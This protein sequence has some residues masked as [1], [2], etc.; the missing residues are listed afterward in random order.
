[1]HAFPASKPFLRRRWAQLSIE[2]FADGRRIRAQELEI[3][4]GSCRSISCQLVPGSHHLDT[5]LDQLN[6]VSSQANCCERVDHLEVKRRRYDC[7]V[8]ARVQRKSLAGS[9]GACLNRPTSSLYVQD[10]P[11]RAELRHLCRLAVEAEHCAQHVPYSAHATCAHLL[12]ALRWRC[13]YSMLASKMADP[14][15]EGNE[16]CWKVQN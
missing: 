7:D 10:V 3:I 6:D 4:V 8:K 16:F 5:D 14:A 2:F 12:D 1:M 15:S 11:A 13:G 9:Q